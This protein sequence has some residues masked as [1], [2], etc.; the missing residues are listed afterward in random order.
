MKND[1]NLDDL[2]I[3]DI[4]PE[5][6]KGK[7]I[8]SII[9]LLIILLI[10]AVVMTR[11]MLGESDSNTTIATQGADDLISPE[12]R[13]DT[14]GQDHEAEKKELDQLSSMMEET[15]TDNDS[16]KEK[17]VQMPKTEAQQSSE[18]KAPVQTEAV[19][20]EPVHTADKPAKKPKINIETIEKESAAPQKQAPAKTEAEH[21]PQA[22]KKE[23]HTAE[24]KSKPKTAPNRN[25]SSGVYYIQVGSFTKEPSKQFL[26]IISR[27]GFHYQLRNHKLLIGPYRSDAAARSDLPRVRNKINKSA[28]IKH[29]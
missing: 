22:K 26:S 10:V 21:K 8:L 2:I 18:A 27:N 4:K 25:S 28:F 13:L 12:L 9:A 1:H 5:K 19:Q 15:L 29:F 3:D 17:S 14:S 16:G 6:S 24:P 20:P 23:V 11:M 7:G